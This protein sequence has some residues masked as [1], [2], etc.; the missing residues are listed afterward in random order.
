MGSIIYEATI[1]VYSVRKRRIVELG[2]MYKLMI[3]I[4]FGLVR[5]LN[6]WFRTLVT[7]SER[8]STWVYQAPRRKK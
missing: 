6:S 2:E 8:G 7:I 3:G 4:F 1:A 5:T